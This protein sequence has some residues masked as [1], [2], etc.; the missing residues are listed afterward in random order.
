MSD[1]HDA[2]PDNRTVRSDSVRSSRSSIL[3]TKSLK[4]RPSKSGR[5]SPTGQLNAPLLKGGI[6]KAVPE[7]D[8]G[9]LLAQFEADKYCVVQWET[10]VFFTYNDPAQD[11]DDGCPDGLM[12][13][14]MTRLGSKEGTSRVQW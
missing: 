12:V 6:P 14:G 4:P 9:W 2:F 8:D 3:S 10:A 5:S 11:G 13:L 1:F 7:E